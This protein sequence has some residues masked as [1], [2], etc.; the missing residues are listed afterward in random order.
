MVAAALIAPAWLA[1]GV[2]GGAVAAAA[3]PTE[4]DPAWSCVRDGNR[5]CGPGNVN[6]A[7]VG[8]Y[9]DQGALVADWP[10]G[11]AAEPDGTA[12][13]AGALRGGGWTSWRLEVLR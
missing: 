7:R 9:D 6:G 5:I 11:V 1:P 2:P 12:A 4:D 10:C 13:I 8:C 3:A